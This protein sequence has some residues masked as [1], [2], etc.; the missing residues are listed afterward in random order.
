M[1]RCRY[2]M[3]AGGSMYRC[4]P[5][6]CDVAHTCTLIIYWELSYSF[7]NDESPGSILIIVLTIIKTSA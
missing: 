5:M 4:R 7:C 2:T 6:H 1:Y 3:G